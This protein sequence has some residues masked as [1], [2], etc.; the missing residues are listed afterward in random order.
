MDHSK[1]LMETGATFQ[2]LSSEDRFRTL[3]HLLD[4]CTPQERWRWQL[5][6][7][8]RLHRDLISWLPVEIAVKILS[9][10]DLPSLF[11][12]A[13]VS[14]TWQSRTNSHLEVWRQHGESTGVRT[15]IASE[16]I[17]E[18]KDA[19]RAGI[20]IRRELKLGRAFAS[21]SLGNPTQTSA[22]FIALDFD[23]GFLAAASFDSSA[24]QTRDWSSL[25]LIWS[26]KRQE[27]IHRFMLAEPQLRPTVV[28][29]LM[30]MYLCV[31]FVDGT[32]HYWDIPDANSV[33]FVGHTGAIFSLAGNL[34]LNLLVSG[35]CDLT[36]RLWNLAT[37]TSIR[38]IQTH[39]NWV[40]TVILWVPPLFSADSRRNDQ[41][42]KRLFTMTKTQIHCFEWKSEKDLPVLQKPYLVIPL[43]QNEGYEELRG[44]FFTP[45]LHYDPK[46]SVISFV[47]QMLICETQT[48]GDAD[49][50]SV[51]AETGVI[52]RSIHI[53]QK[54]RKLLSVGNRFALI[55]L[56]YVDSKYKN[57][58]IIDLQSRKLIGGAT[59]PHSRASTPD[60]SQIAVGHPGWLD[61]LSSELSSNQDLVIALRVNNGTIHTLK[62]H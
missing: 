9:Y 35:S 6:L 19:L 28:K 46:A 34:E 18:W 21:G 1:W 42:K 23:Q 62:W 55:L 29:L 61:G 25:I 44:E 36:V 40:V 51:C 5:E 39:D 3:V 31:G 13:Q 57:L 58:G 15:P 26:L 12:A 48:I 49:I 10:L 8:E 53:N 2:K 59:V 56:P 7:T 11:S 60:F 50:I 45:G 27:V 20:R 33:R 14:R 32:I 30:P 22:Q 41:L 4:L 52:K 38:T 24:E 17:Q 54:I 16:S 47:R 37:G 43:K